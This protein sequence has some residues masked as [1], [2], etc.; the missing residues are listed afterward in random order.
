MITSTSNAK[1]KRLV[2]LRKKRKAR[3]TEKVFLT[4][5][6]RMFEEVPEDRLLEIYVTE[7]FYKKEKALV[8]AKHKKSG[9]QMEVLTDTVMNFVSDTKTPQGVLCV[10]AQENRGE[11]WLEK[12]LKA[13]EQVPL[14]MLLDNLQDPGNM[15][16]ILRTA[17]AAAVTG[18]IMSSDC[19]DVYNPK[20]IRSTMGSVFRVPF[21][22]VENVTDVIRQMKEHG[23]RTY[24]THLAGELAYDEPD[25]RTPSAFFVGNEGNG[26]RDQVAEL[27]DTYIKIPMAGQ[28]ESLNAAIA[29]TVVMFEAGRQRRH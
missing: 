15:G 29:A 14:I 7:H 2:N 23:I 5:G 8:D 9:C 19:V 27:A 25:Y 20:V 28:V 21:V 3:D 17:E 10:V 1:V 16:T 4:E 11:A 13:P 22:Y 12:E 18:I 6:L 24:A 26:L